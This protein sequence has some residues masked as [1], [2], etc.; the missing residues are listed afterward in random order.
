MTRTRA[1][2]EQEIQQLTVDGY[3][4]AQLEYRLY[5]CNQQIADWN[6]K[7]ARLEELEAAQKQAQAKVPT[8]VKVT[9]L[10]IGDQLRVQPSGTFGIIYLFVGL[11]YIEA[12]HVLCHFVIKGG[13]NAS[14]N[15][16]HLIRSAE[17]VEQNMEMVS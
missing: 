3:T 14:F 11:E 5:D 12:A 17:W 15:T 6:Q 13:Y 4:R 9:E 7:L 1:E 8:P 2:I 10:K 16:R